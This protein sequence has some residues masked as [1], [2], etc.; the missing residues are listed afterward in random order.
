MHPDMLRTL[1][2]ARQDDLLNTYPTTRRPPRARL[3]ERRP[4]FTRSRHK[5]GSLLIRTGVR[6]IGD[7]RAEIELA[8]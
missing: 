6:L 5:L 7:R 2:K 1:A 8:N 4:Q 3:S